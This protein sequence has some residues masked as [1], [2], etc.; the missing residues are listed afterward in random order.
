MKYVIA[1]LLLFPISAF[2]SCDTVHLIVSTHHFHTDADFTETNPGV[3]LE[4][5]HVGLGVYKNS[6][7]VASVAAYFKLNIASSE[8]YDLNIAAG[9]MTGYDDVPVM[10]LAML[11]S[12]FYIRHI[13]I[14]IGAFPGYI[15]SSENRRIIPVLVGAISYR[16]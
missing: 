15:S 10:P 14:T 9:A 4:C 13:G 6:Y 16:F 12:S 7:A 5:G 1:L 11:Y 2:A 3:I 8:H